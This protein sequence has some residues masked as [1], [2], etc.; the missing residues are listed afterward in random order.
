MS[1]K[2]ESTTQVYFHVRESSN[3]EY[4]RD[5]IHLRKGVI[6]MKQMKCRIL[7]GYL[8]IAIIASLIAIPAGV[9][10]STGTQAPTIEYLEDIIEMVKDRYG[11]A[12][13]DDEL[14][15]GALRGIFDTMDPYTGYYDN[16]QAESFLDSIG[17]TYQGIGVS[18][19]N[20]G[21]YVMIID[22]FE[23][24]PAEM[25][26]ILPGD[27]ILSVNG[28]DV[29]GK[30][31]EAVRSL[32]VGDEGTLVKLGISR[33]GRAQILVFE[34]KRQTIKINPVKYYIRDGIGYLKISSFN[35]NVEE[36]VNRALDEFDSNLV[37][38]VILDL[39]GNPGGDVG[40]AISCAR[41]FIPAGLIARLD[42]KS[43][44][45]SDIVYYSYL[46]KQKYELAVLVND[47][48]ASA[49]EIVAGAVQDRRCGTLIGTT[50]FGKAKVQNMV[51]LLT[52][53]AKARYM[54]QYGIDAVDAYD[55]LYEGIVPL[56]EEILGWVKMTTGYYYTPNGRMID[57]IGLH[58]DII[59]NGPGP[60]NDVMIT[61]LHNLSITSKPGL[62]AE[63]VD[64]YYAE[65]I[66]KA[67]GYDVDEPDYKLDGKTFKAIARFQKD[68]GL[69][70]Y[71]VLDFSTQ[72]AMNDKIY[73]LT[74]EYDLQYMKAMEMLLK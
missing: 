49:S 67:A 44:H 65:N 33:V 50:T 47:M 7:I 16:Q 53:E 46:D 19:E 64:V 5:R 68:R 54:A 66:L 34:M 60:V 40:Q 17:G 70:P 58:P 3:R 43:D 48:S 6:P 24:S 59:V 74:V 22:V 14:I 30:T 62:N 35:A 37:K 57:N 1:G 55:L 52:P 41:K 23:A 8:A 18:L 12:I 27:I 2:D 45:Y 9:D 20:A 69:Y 26:G 51:A 15:E 4:M 38:K 73:E 28:A 31:V 21:G 32:I 42:F 36:F 13:T 63:S 29:A 25:A 11:G 10:A 39:R 72:R 61:S 56:D 71:G